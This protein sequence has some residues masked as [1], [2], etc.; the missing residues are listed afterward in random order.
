MNAFDSSI[1]TYLLHIAPS[2]SV[3]AHAV[4]VIA[5]FYVFKGVLPLAIV[6]AI[7]FQPGSSLEYR[8][9]TVVAI[10]ASALVAFIVGRLLALALPF[11]LRPIFDPS[12][13]LTFPGADHAGS[14][15]RLWSS[16][17]SDHAA[18]WM[19]LAVGIFIVWRWIGVLAI[20][21]CVLFICAP[22][23]Y[24]GLHYPTDVIAGAMIGALVV[25]LMTRAPIRT[26]FAPHVVRF[27]NRRP[28][29]AY[30]LAFVLFFELAT[31][32]DEPRSLIISLYK[33][34]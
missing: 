6:W 5:E 17:P 4:G 32:F 23:V 3:F 31:M 20:V 11:R 15:L 19:S 2:S 14:H 10:L 26:R 33:A 13:G 9:E 30:M 7:W 29:I 8:R 28:G 1:Q 18:L 21:Q 25:V 34:M 16:F 12:L 24:L 22:R 27:M